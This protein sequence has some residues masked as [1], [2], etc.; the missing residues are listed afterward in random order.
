MSLANKKN[1]LFKL[2]IVV[3]FGKIVKTHME[4]HHQFLNLFSYET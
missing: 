3:V 4:I 2:L 1:K